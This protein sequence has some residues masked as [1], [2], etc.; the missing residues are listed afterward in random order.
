MP[1][2]RGATNASVM[3]IAQ[4]MHEAVR[5]WQKANGQAPAPPWSQAPKWM[6]EA[7]REAVVWRMEN[8][9]APSSTQHEQWLAEKRAA[10]W[11]YGKVKNGAKKTHPLMVSYADLP[12]VER[13]KDAM[14]GALIDSLI[15]PMK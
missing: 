15:R 6:K 9:Q 14:V 5:A 12:Q 11:R 8:P 1:M 2:A 3:K 10:G 4:V 7:S 13:R